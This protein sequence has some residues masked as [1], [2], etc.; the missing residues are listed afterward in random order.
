MIKYF[1]MLTLMF[2]FS[3][4][5]TPKVMREDIRR[6]KVGDCFAMISRSEILDRNGRFLVRP[7]A[8]VIDIVFKITELDDKDRVYIMTFHGGRDDGLYTA[9]DYDFAD[10]NYQRVNCDEKYNGI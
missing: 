9:K 8:T 5:S 1:S 4:S 7:T 2:V 10:S 6:F 3:C